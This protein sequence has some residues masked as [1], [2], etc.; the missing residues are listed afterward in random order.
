MNIG[1]HLI[2]GIMD[3]NYDNNS[4][5]ISKMQLLTQF[6]NENINEKPDKKKVYKCSEFSEAKKFNMLM[7]IV[8]MTK[9]NPNLID[10]IKKKKSQI[11]SENSEGWTPLMLACRNSYICSS[12]ETVKELIKY[13]ADVNKKDKQG[14]T[15]LMKACSYCGTDSRETIVKILLENGADVHIKDNRGW[16][17]LMCM[18]S[19]NADTPTIYRLIL[20]K[21][22]MDEMDNN[23]YSPLDIT[24][25]SFTKNISD[26]Y[27]KDIYS[28][29][30]AVLLNNGY[31][32]EFEKLFEL[33]NENVCRALLNRYKYDY[34]KS[35]IL[36]QYL[37]K[38]DLFEWTDNMKFNEMLK[39]EL[40][41][42]YVN[43][44]FKPENIIYLCSE[45]SFNLK[46][47]IKEYSKKLKFLF[48][49]KDEQDLINKISFYMKD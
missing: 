35:I 4:I 46:N 45:A 28:K 20:S 26:I 36:M 31:T 10:Q 24:Y 8:L 1:P 39:N 49:V 37:D 27:N 43:I 7:K 48:D 16:N 13:G 32:M 15:A 41:E 22:K 30:I 40:A 29:K 9:K 5:S 21:S 19:N 11:N 17:A 14:L 12:E 33:K 42:Q 44:Y 3:T 2:P 23:G 47:G 38:Y 18:C 25:R 34:K 6:D